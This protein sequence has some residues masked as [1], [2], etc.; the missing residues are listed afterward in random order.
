[1]CQVWASIV[2]SMLSLTAVPAASETSLGRVDFRY[3]PPWW[4]SAICLP[5]DPEKTLVGKEGQILLEFGK[6]GV[7]NFGI[8]LQPEL[9]A[10]S[11]WLKQQTIS[12]RAPIVQTFQRAGEVDLLEEAF[13]VI[14]GE[15]TP[16]RRVVVLNTLHN[17]SAADGQVPARLE[18][19]QQRAGPNRA[20]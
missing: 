11:N 1:M 19:P 4:Q 3:A 8:V 18:D 17:S 15:S 16:L 13:V 6:K 5:D 9:E 12:P 2:L 7:R 10:K 20:A 14:G